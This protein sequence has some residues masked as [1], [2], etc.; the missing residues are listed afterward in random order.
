MAAQEYRLGIDIGSTTAKVAILDSHD[1]IQFSRYRRHHAETKRTVAELL[2]EAQREFGSTPL[3]ACITGSSGMMLAKAMDVP[4]EQEVVALKHA[5][6]AQLPQTDVA[7]ELGGEDAKIV[8]FDGSI[9]QRMN[10]SCAGGTGAFIDQMAT[11]M[12]TDAAGLNALA[13]RA[14]KIYPI[15]SHCG[16]FAK[17][18]V[19]PLLNEGAHK[20]DI[21]ASIFQAVVNQT[22]AGLACGRPVKG[23]VAFLGGPLCYL[24]ELKKRFIDTLNLDDEHALQPA[25]SNLFVA[26]GAAQC[27]TGK[28]AFTL[29]DLI[30][31]LTSVKDFHEADT[32]FLPALFKNKAELEAFQTRHAKGAL[33]KT[34]L[35]FYTGNAYLGIDAG[36][37]T[38][39]LALIA[40]D[41]GMLYHSYGHNNG[42]VIGS[43]KRELIK[44]YEAID[45]AHASITLKHT[46]VTGYGEQLL[47][48]A[49]NAD[50]GEIETIAH[51]RAAQSLDPSVD[52]VLDIG[53]QDMKCLK[54]HNGV[55]ESI[56]L[57]EACSSGCGSFI[58]SFAD[59][60]GYSVQ[61]FAAKA[62]ESEHPVD[63]G[64]RCTVFM[65][66]K[67]KQTQKE[68]ASI[69]DISAGLSYSV[70]KNS[71]FKVIKARDPKALGNHMVVQGGTFL[72][73]A[74][75]RAFELLT[76]SDAIRPTEA[77]LM[78]AY[79]AAL[80]AKQ[81]ACQTST[82]ATSSVMN[83]EELQAL[84]VTQKH[85]RCR[86][87]EN[88]CPLTI[89]T[90]QN[91]DGSKRMSI[92]GNRCE[93]GGLQKAY[94]E[95]REEQRKRPNLYSW[96]YERVFSY[97]PLPKH[98]AYRGTVGI[99]RAL[100]M[101]E[102]YPFWH[103]FFTALGFRVELSSASSKKVFEAGMESIPSESVC[104]PAKLAHG[105]VMN[106]L[107]K[108]VDF[109][110]MPCIRHERQ[111]D[112]G[113]QNCFNCP[114]VSSYP[115]ALRLNI[116]ALAQKH[117]PLVDPYIPY[118]SKNK[119]IKRLTTVL[120][121]LY[122]AETNLVG[123]APS[124]HEIKRA[125]KA[126]LKEDA[127]FKQDVHKAGED[128]LAYVEQTRGHAIILAGRPYHIDPE[129][130]H[131]LPELIAGLGFT[132]L[133]EDSVAHLA[134][135]ERDLRAIDQWMYHSRL[136]S[137]AK[138]ATIRSDVDVVQLNSFGCGL[139]AITTDEIAE[140]MEGAGKLYTSLKI[141]EVS[142]LGTAKIRLRSL[143]AAL[144]SRKN[145]SP[146]PT[147]TAWPKVSF[148]KEMKEEGY[149]I[150]APQMAPIH[151]E[152]LEAAIRSEGYNLK[153]LPADDPNAVEAGLKYTNNDI[154]YPSILV[155]GQIMAAIE[156]GEYD[157]ERT[158]VL[159]VQTGGGCRATNYI[160][161]IRKALKESGHP[162]IPVIS[163]SFKSIGEN[164]PGW[165][166]S[167]GFVVKAY[168][169]LVM[170]DVLMQCLYRTRPYETEVGSANALY[171]HWMDIC[172]TRLPYMDHR[173]YLDL[174][175]AI[176]SDFDE[177]PLTNDGSKP[178]VGVVGEIL[179][180]Y[181]PLANNDVV[182]TIEREGCEAVVPGLT[183]FFQYAGLNSKWYHRD[184]DGSLLSSLGGQALAWAVKTFKDEVTEALATSKRFD[185]PSDIEELSGKAENIL[186]LCNCMGEGWLLTAEMIELIEHDTPNIVVCSP[187]ACLPNHVVGKAVAKELR[188]QYPTANPVFI[189]YD[190]GASVVNQVNRIKLMISVAKDATNDS[191]PEASSV[192]AENTLTIS[193][194]QGK[195]APIE[196]SLQPKAEVHLELVRTQQKQNQ[197]EKDTA[198]DLS[199]SA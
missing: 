159:I 6:K 127:A 34:E 11:L 32:A 175:K 31:R 87:C 28:N 54:I 10:G 98:E 140:I 45:S 101:Y 23:T 152:L 55:I 174:C 38:F 124:A 48:D 117:I 108:D 93:R 74:V 61:D 149:T 164:N 83:T 70:V 15:A 122:E 134:R 110:F 170:G 14:T 158:A 156:S 199:M 177:L 180:K 125:V 119:L 56:L 91:I 191:V 1:E 196:P 151:F 131:G 171:R 96:K 42:E 194:E 113:A 142:N 168:Y 179:A 130:N 5:I 128:A 157:L 193:S 66:S 133:T 24:P 85:A 103:T 47:I 57:N 2:A 95:R 4:F 30:E 18:D 36:S 160:A 72:N 118:R 99:P 188:A 27:S 84:I 35:D 16:V 86:R 153:V 8:Y 89:N 161:L 115:E 81:R 65:N 169:S 173:E 22:I 37:T 139:D 116:D 73:D 41:G 167:P 100:N 62:L 52:F 111:E 120:A 9:E 166:Y 82:Q 69:A 141:D 132:V 126:A 63:L 189:D 143:A 176:I 78:G 114:I 146:K 90:F 181:H 76:G 123:S 3:S 68:G 197:A 137:A 155:T 109:I 121:D 50:S 25:L 192:F 145:E 163:L 144:E 150:L 51:L 7:I 33:P 162:N 46:T 178:K 138:F 185:A 58:E 104:Y 102:N 67:V 107:G 136:Y 80:I 40:E 12:D 106:L 195:K 71:L 172:R 75:L 129:I 97:E 186:Q 44:L 43:A 79:G 26:I 183:D 154:C 49:I 94:T 112:P 13:S 60:M 77:G 105:H 39:K 92:T 59:S 29:E 187:F 64:S 53:G 20:E 198:H 147:S 190:P 148:T 88:N 17:S 165:K 182:A 135:P 19:Q 21:A 184:L